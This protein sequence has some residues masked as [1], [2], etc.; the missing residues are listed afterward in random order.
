M[1][2][3]MTWRVRVGIVVAG[4]MLAGSA[5]AAAPLD[6]EENELR[7][8]LEAEAP[9]MEATLSEWV[10][11]N[12][13]SWNPSGLE[14]LAALL[15]DALAALE[16]AVEVEPGASPGL[17][18]LEDARTGPLLVAR[19]E[20]RRPPLGR[21]T[22]VL[23]VGH[24]DTV[25][26]P[27]SPFQELRRGASQRATGPGV[28]DMKGGL[29]VLFWALRGLART[30]DLDRADWTVLLNADEEI[31]SLVSRGA[32]EREAQRA[33]YGFVFEAAQDG[34]A[35][36]RSRRGLG[37]FHLDIDGTAAHAGSS[38]AKGRSALAELAHKILQIEA[39]TDYDRGITL[40][41]GV[42]RGGSKRN[43][44]PDHAEAWVD[45]RYD[46]AEQGEQIRRELEAIAQR[47]Q[48]DGTRTTLWGTLHRPPKAATPE[49][50][51]L[52]E[53]HAGVAEA[54]GI[55]LPAP[56][57][58][59]GGTDGSLMAAVGLPTLDSMGVVGADAHTRLEHLEL[60]SLPERAILAALLLRR[61]IRSDAPPAGR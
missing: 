31:G 8:A 9:A 52:L 21:A 15:A 41:V 43:I 30:G 3:S 45:L 14:R 48:V 24:Y 11:I 12:T 7:V 60:Q 58:A 13:G 19:R 27:D 55:G 56:V 39:L 49:M 6:A 59:G 26:E 53:A 44:V 2:G 4:G 10:A 61:L 28:A 1:P 42:A 18:G 5:H 35:M 51:G 50:A 20:A 37:Q 38:H 16:F 33:E 47:A 29:V 46:R 36:V 34:G 23:L 17:P 25:F 40:N 32:I 54:L 22:R 57:H